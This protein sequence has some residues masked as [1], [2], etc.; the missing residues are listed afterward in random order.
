MGFAPS[1]SG[2]Q[3]EKIFREVMQTYSKFLYLKNPE[4]GMWIK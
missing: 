4:I 2:K 3:I 1:T